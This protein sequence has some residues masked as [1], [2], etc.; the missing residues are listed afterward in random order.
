M[1]DRYAAIGVTI[2]VP[3]DRVEDR[4]AGGERIAGRPGRA[5]D[6]EPVGDER[7]EVR[8]VDRHV[9]AADPREGTAGDDDVVEG[10]CAGP[11]EELAAAHDPALERHALG[12]PVAVIDDLSEDVLEL[13]GLGL[14]EEADLAEVDPEDRDIDLVPGRGPRGGMSRRH[15]ARR[16]RPWSAGAT[17][18]PAGRLTAPASGRRRGSGTSRRRAR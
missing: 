15:R 17:G 2:E 11:W 7:R 16:A 9:E 10:E 8:A 4:A 13:A 1:A 18:A 6:D 12:D 3:A 14:R 5:G